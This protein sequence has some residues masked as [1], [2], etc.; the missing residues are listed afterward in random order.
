MQEQT[1]VLSDKHHVSQTQWVV[2]MLHKPNSDNP[3]HVL[4]VV[5]GRNGFGQAILRRYGLYID[6][7]RELGP[8][9]RCPYSQIVIRPDVFCSPQD[10]KAQL[11]ILINAEEYYVKAWE[12]TDEQARQL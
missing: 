11:E 2:G 4:L 9:T 3:H 1:S 10:A 6:D 12:V 8:E 7:K 5:E